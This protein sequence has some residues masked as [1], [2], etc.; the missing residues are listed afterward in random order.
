[1]KYPD[2]LVGWLYDVASS[3]D[4]RVSI[5]HILEAEKFW[6]GLMDDLA[7]E[8]WQRKIVKDQLEGTGSSNK[9]DEITE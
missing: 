3:L 2:E 1:M 4:W 7:T 6:P 5:L 9:T 8:A